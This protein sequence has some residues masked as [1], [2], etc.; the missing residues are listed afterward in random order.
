L[1]ITFRAISGVLLFPGV[2]AFRDDHMVSR[3]LAKSQ[4]LP[5]EHDTK[6]EALD[7][8]DEIEGKLLQRDLHPLKNVLVDQ[9]RIEV[10]KILTD[11]EDDPFLTTSMLADILRYSRFGPGATSNVSGRFTNSDK[12]KSET[13]VS[14]ALRPFLSAIKSGQWGDSNT[15]YV[16]Y[17]A[18]KIN[19][20]PKTAFT[21][22]TIS[23]MPTA[24]MYMQLG[25]AKVLELRLRK[26][27]VD[28]RD[29]TKNQNL[30]KRANVLKLAT[31]DLS[32]A[33]SW[34]S[35]R[36]MENIL[37]PDLLHLVEILR[38]HYCFTSRDLDFGPI[39]PRRMMNIM[40]MGAGYTF[41]LMTLVFLALIRVIVPRSCLN[42]CAV[43]GDDL[44]VPQ[45]YADTLIE[46]LE[47]LGFQVN[48]NKSFT[49]GNFFESCGTEWLSGHDVRPFYCRKGSSLE[50]DSTGLAIPYRVQIA[51]S[52][53]LWSKRPDGTCDIR[54]L[55]IWSMLTKPLRKDEKPKVP[56]CLGNVGLITSLA[57]TTYKHCDEAV[58]NGWDPIYRVKTLVK[59]PQTTGGNPPGNLAMNHKFYPY[60]LWLMR[61]SEELTTTESDAKCV[62]Y[63]VRTFY[64]KNVDKFPKFI[65]RLLKDDAR[66][67]SEQPACVF[68]HGEEP[69]R[70]LFGSI[71]TLKIYSKW[72]DGLLWS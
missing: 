8:F 62:S 2:S 12:L 14:P 66:R 32:S 72:P 63:R 67:Y 35:E 49:K 51:N 42:L 9:M 41:A 56:E 22:R 60:L 3:V 10:L 15:K 70:G 30:A 28:I 29:Q 5:F 43:Y 52:L 44:I 33:S 18:S 24:N 1:D 27:G 54:F 16:I 37:P 64:Y 55:P 61:H 36:N 23:T 31:I 20:V 34:F 57:E 19:T 65:I 53:R 45:K 21:D 4:Q 13:S 40:P 50:D 59:K 25:L 71:K 47:A 17:P 48:C 26:N 58:K 6:K 39:Q 46:H 7:L 69:I 38:P 68:T 11:S